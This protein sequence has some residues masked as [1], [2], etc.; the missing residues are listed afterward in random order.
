[1]KTKHLTHRRRMDISYE[2]DRPEYKEGLRK[3]LLYN[4]GATED[5]FLEKLAMLVAALPGNKKMESYGVSVVSHPV[6][7][8]LEVP[9]RHYPALFEDGDID[10]S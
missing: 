1:M 3:Y 6:S 7:R 8:L 2:P 5:D 10:T 4:P 9:V